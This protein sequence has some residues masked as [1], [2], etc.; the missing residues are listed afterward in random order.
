[1][2]IIDNAGAHPTARIS[3]VYSLVRYSI[4]IILA[5]STVEVVHSED[6]ESFLEFLL[7]NYSLFSFYQQNVPVG[8]PPV[9]GS[10]PNLSFHVL[11]LCNLLAYGQL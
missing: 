6:S 11:G 9:M 2:S 7:T 1:M 10:S 5:T 8:F 4:A 3:V